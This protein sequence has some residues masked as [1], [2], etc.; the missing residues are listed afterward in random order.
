MKGRRFVALFFLVVSLTGCKTGRPSW[1]APTPTT[2]EVVTYHGWTNCV[3][4]WNSQAEVIVVPAIN[5]VMSFRFLNSSNVFWE[6]C[7][8]DGKSGDASGAEW[9]NFGGDK[10]WPSPEADW[11]RHTG[12]KKW[13]PPA[14]FDA[15]PVSARIDNNTVVLTSPVDRHYGIRVMRRVRLSGARL[16]IDTSYE[17]LFGE[18]TS[19]GIWTITQFRDPLSVFVPLPARSIFTNG[20]FAFGNEPWP[21]LRRSNDWLII[22]RDPARA[23]KMGCDAERLV[24]AGEKEVCVVSCWRWERREYPDRGASAEVYTNPDPKAYVELELLGPLSRLKPG[25]KT[26]FTTHYEL[27]R[28]TALKPEQD[29]ARVLRGLGARQTV[30]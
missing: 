14:A 21:Q 1:L 7:S 9:V 26:Q 2:A 30:Q 13:M 11:S 29:V 4:L 3:R 27:F 17:R 12:R 6:D 19:V 28:R 18:P 8:L 5:R 16:S 25:D 22:T 15:L 20:Y 23:H 10:T 24:W